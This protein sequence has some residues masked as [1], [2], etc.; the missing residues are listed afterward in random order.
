MHRLHDPANPH[1]GIAIA[2][3]L[4]HL[5]TILSQAHNCE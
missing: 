4:A 2:A 5:L 1:I 3:Q